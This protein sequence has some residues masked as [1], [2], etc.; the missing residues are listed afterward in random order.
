MVRL[1]P[2][3]LAWLIAVAPVPAVA[4]GYPPP[5]NAPPQTAAVFAPQQLDQM[6]APVALYPDALLAQVLM[7]AT[8]PLDVIAADRWIQDPA[9]ARLRGDNMAAALDQQP[10]DPSVKSLVP[11]PQVLKMMDSRLDWMQQLGDAFLAQPDD[12]MAAVQRLRAAA[13]AAGTLVSTPQETVAVQADGTIV[14]VPANPDVV[15]VPAYNPDVVYGTWPYPEYPPVYIPPP[16]G[17]AV[18]GL[19]F[20]IGIAIVVPLWGWDHFDWDHRRIDIDRDRFNHIN[21]GRPPVTTDVWRHDPSR[22]GAVPYRDPATRAQYQRPLPGPAPDTRRDFRGYAP[23]QGAAAPQAARPTQQAR[24]S[25]QPGARPAPQPQA[26]RPA[27]PTPQTQQA[28][29]PSAQP[30][31][32]LT[33]QP[34]ATRPAAS[35]PQTQQAAR[36]PAQPSARPSTPQAQPQVTRPSAP[37]PQ[38][39]QAARPQAQPVARPTPQPQVFRPAAPAPQSVFQPAAPGP[40]TRAFSQRGQQSRQTPVAAPPARAAPAPQRAAPAPAPQRSAAPPPH[41]AP[42]QGGQQGGGQQH[43]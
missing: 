27:A 35:T 31:A 41:P 42:P 36:P 14:I 24:P 8:Y 21:R 25:A 4:Q 17:Y 1:F 20:G 38:M 23:P 9:N 22:R 5:P 39:Q 13:R 16:P 18:S 33:Q 19:F 10:W 37:T 6:L 15:Y 43:R 34:Q 3:L 28:A 32:R 26:T 12:V 29:R 11:F 30:G 40:D 7:A 2:L